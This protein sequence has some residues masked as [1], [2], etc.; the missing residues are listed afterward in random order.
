MIVVSKKMA[1]ILV[2]SNFAG[3][4]IGRTSEKQATLK[5]TKREKR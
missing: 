5:I 4:K 3:T 1:Q 2:V